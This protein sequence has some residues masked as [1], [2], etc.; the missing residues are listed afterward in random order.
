MWIIAL[1]AIVAVAILI[2]AFRIVLGWVL[3]PAALA[4]FDA[5]ASRA[6][7]FA[8]KLLIVAAAGMILWIAWML[9][10]GRI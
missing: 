10:T 1:L 3:S 8:G 4:R 9:S 2:G 6:V 5:G 7:G